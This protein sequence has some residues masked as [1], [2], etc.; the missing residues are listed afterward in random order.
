MIMIKEKKGLTQ[1]NF[2]FLKL[3]N[4]LEVLLLKLLIMKI[5]IKKSEFWLFFYLIIKIKKYL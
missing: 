5:I 1:E 3:N 2:W 4:H